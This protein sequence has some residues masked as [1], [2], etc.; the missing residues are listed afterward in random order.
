MARIRRTEDSTRVY[1]TDQG[2][3]RDTEAP[4]RRD[5][6]KPGPRVPEHPR[7]G[8]V[9]VSR[10][11]AGRGGKTVTLVTGLPASDVDAVGARLKKLCGSGG[12][13]RDGVVEIQGD[14]RERVVAHLSDAYT[15]KLAGG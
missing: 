11:K 3:I 4:T 14:H 9:R 5:R 10:S 15:T 1:S 12:T 8:V 6:T 13:V 7:D 2:R